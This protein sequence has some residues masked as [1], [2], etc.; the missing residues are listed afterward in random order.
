MKDRELLSN[1]QPCEPVAIEVAT[2]DIRTIKTRGTLSLP[3]HSGASQKCLTIK[4]VLYAP[5]FSKNLLSH[6]KLEKAGI[7]TDLRHRALKMT[8]RKSGELYAKL[9]VAGAGLYRIRDIDAKSDH[10]CMSAEESKQTL[11]HCRL[12]HLNYKAMQ[13]LQD[14]KMATGLDFDSV[15][16]GEF[17]EACIFGKSHRHKFVRFNLVEALEMLDMI[18]T[19]V[20]GPMEVLGLSREKYFVTF[21]DVKSRFIEVYCLR[22]KSGVFAAYKRFEARYTTE[23]G[24]KVKCLCSDNGGEYTSKAMEDYLKSRGTVHQLTHADS[25]QENGIAER[26]NRTLVEMAR[27]CMNFAQVEKVL[28]PQAI[29][30]SAY[31][32]NRCPTTQLRSRRKKSLICRIL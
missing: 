6:A 1:L 22:F 25:P 2:G 23:L 28:W 14:Q 9:E 20:V 17:C 19:D 4:D 16:K 5:S 3:I 31:I 15:G 11:W 24:R 32:R 26:V 10:S 8:S 21:I 27:A 12:G 30:Y 7:E 18:V 13:K 29:R